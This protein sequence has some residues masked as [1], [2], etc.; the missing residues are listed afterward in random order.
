MGGLWDH[1][2]NESLLKWLK[3]IKITFQVFDHCWLLISNSISSSYLILIHWHLLVC[4]GC[5]GITEKK[6]REDIVS[7]STLFYL[8]F[9]HGNSIAKNVF[10]NYLRTA[11]SP[12]SGIEIY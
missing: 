7:I 11:I 1:L 4:E 8:G 9:L 5:K 6:E 3:D 10:L 12:K 2:F